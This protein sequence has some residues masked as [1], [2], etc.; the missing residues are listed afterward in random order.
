M[1]QITL[2]NTP[3][4]VKASTRPGKKLQATFRNPKTGKTN[5]IHFGQ[6]GAAVYQD[7]TGLLPRNL[8]HNDPKRRASYRARHQHDRLNELSPGSLSWLLLW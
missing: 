6:A 4:Q 7:K 5:T 3:L 8:I 1:K 2:F